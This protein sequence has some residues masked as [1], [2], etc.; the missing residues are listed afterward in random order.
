MKYSK[1]VRSILANQLSNPSEDFV[2]FFASKFYDG[3]ITSKLMEQFT[4]IVKKSV[5]Q[6]ITD[7]INDRLKAALS[8]ESKGLEEK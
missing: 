4:L 3:R 5:N 8:T 7:T 1:E 6:F 2:K